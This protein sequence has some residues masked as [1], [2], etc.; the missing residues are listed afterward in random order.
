MSTSSPL[1]LL[2][3]LLPPSLLLLG[4]EGYPNPLA[5]K[6]PRASSASGNKPVEAAAAKYL[7]AFTKSTGNPLVPVS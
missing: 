6:M 4:V 1:S 7:R 5:A 2:L 3:L